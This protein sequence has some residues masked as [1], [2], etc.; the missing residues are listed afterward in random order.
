CSSE[1]FQGDVN[2][3]HGFGLRLSE[4]FQGDVN[5]THGFGLRF[6]PVGAKQV[7]QAPGTP[8]PALFF[9]L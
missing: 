8:S 2:R 9:C 1:L 6:A 4:L 7:P 3:T 5:R